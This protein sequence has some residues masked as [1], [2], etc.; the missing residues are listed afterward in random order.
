MHCADNCANGSRDGSPGRR[1]RR[2]ADDLRHVQGSGQAMS[3]TE[4][5]LVEKDETAGARAARSNGAEM[6]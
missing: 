5:H 3:F 4:V 2:V 6:E 1:H